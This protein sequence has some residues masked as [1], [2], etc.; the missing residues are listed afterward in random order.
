M[1][2]V[3]KHIGG[4]M[5]SMRADDLPERER[6][7]AKEG[8]EALERIH[9]RGDSHLFAGLAAG[10]GVMLLSFML[11]LNS[12]ASFAEIVQYCAVAIAASF[13]AGFYI[14][15]AQQYYNDNKTQE[16]LKHVVRAM[17]ASWRF[18]HFALLY[19]SNSRHLATA[20]LNA[21]EGIKMLP[22]KGS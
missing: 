18:K 2:R 4:A 11:I 12:S 16:D 13:K 21:P 1:E 5:I 8:A 9:K 22:P 6:Q 17:K 7:L 19:M 3:T 10:G 20:L 15:A 14:G